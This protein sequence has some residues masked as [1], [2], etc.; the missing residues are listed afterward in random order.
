MC[1][2]FEAEEGHIYRIEMTRA[3]ISD[4]YI[5]LYAPDGET[6]LYAS[7]VESVVYEFDDGG[8]YFFR[9]R[10]Y[11][12]SGRG[13]YTVQITDLGLDDHADVAVGAT[14]LSADGVEVTGSLET[15]GDVDYFALQ[16]DGSQV[17]QLNTTGVDVRITV[18]AQDA[19]TRIGYTGSSLLNIDVDSAGLYYV[20]IRGDASSTTGNYTLSV[21]D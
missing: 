13:D 19:I 15:R 6:S 9:V 7:N 11:Q 21:I 1:D 18:Y 5:Y 4:G 3:G 14:P 12:A 2:H 17:Y 16:L 10:H 20:D 8:R